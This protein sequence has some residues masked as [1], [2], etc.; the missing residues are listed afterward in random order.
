MSA[1]LTLSLGF[2]NQGRQMYS[3]FPGAEKKT[4]AAWDWSPMIPCGRVLVDV[5]RDFF[6]KCED[7]ADETGRLFRGGFLYL[8][9]DRTVD[10]SGAGNCNATPLTTI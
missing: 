6:R 2:T 8:C 7:Q 1:M 9:C 4:E 3:P 10:V 5:A